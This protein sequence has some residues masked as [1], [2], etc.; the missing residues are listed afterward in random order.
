MKIDG[1]LVEYAHRAGPDWRNGYA[2][3][4]QTGINVSYLLPEREWGRHTLRELMAL[5]SPIS[6]SPL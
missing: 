4:H 6:L 1:V 5:D 2:E 3:S